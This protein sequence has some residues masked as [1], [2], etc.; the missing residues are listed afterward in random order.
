MRDK[1]IGVERHEYDQIA[2]SKQFF[3][4]YRVFNLINHLISLKFKLRS[5]T[6]KD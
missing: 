2:K 6:K 3:P 1:G 4:K 5:P